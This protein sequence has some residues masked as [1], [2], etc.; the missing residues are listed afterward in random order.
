MKTYQKFILCFLFVLFAVSL[1]AQTP[2]GYYNNANDIQ[3]GAPLKTAFFHII[4]NPGVISYNGLWNAF[5]TTDKRPDGKVWDMYSDIPGGTPPYLYTFVTDQCGNYT[6]EGMCYNREHSMPKSWFNEAAPMNSDLFHIYPTDGYVNGRRGNLP[7]GEVGIYS[8]MSQNGSKIG[9]N[10]FDNYTATVFEPIDDYKG[11]FARSYFYMVTAFEDKVSNWNSAQL[12]NNTYPAFSAWSK[13]LL[14]KWHRMDPVSQKEIDRNNA[15]YIIQKNR[16]PYIDFPD[17]AEYVWGNK[18]N[19]VFHTSDNHNPENP[20]EA[21]Q[22]LVATDITTHSFVANWTAVSNATEYELEV[23]S[24]TEGSGT[25]VVLSENFDG[26]T[27]GQPNSSASSANI[28]ANI[29]DYTQ[30]PGWSGTYVFQA[31]GSAKFGSSSSLGTLVTPTIDLSAHNGSFNLYFEAM[32]WSGDSKILKIYLNDVLAHTVTDLN[33]DATYTFNDYTITVNGGTTSSVIRFEGGQASKGRFF[34][35][36]ISVEQGTPS[37]TTP[38]AGSPFTGIIETSQPVIQLNN[39]STYFYRV[40][41]KNASTSSIFSNEIAVELATT[42]IDSDHVS[43]KIYSAGD[44]LYVWLKNHVSE[45]IEIYSLLGNKLV[46]MKG[47]SG[48]NV[49]PLQSMKGNVVMVKIGGYMQKVWVR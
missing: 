39:T 40:R 19:E 25:N 33:N 30:T 5:K 27:Q 43:V 20:L 31:G 9:Q 46:E 14:M 8:W 4:K 6:G 42:H 44:N 34:L 24:K 3:G 28:A 10:T 29:N 37:V 45:K 16:N 35:E 22:A 47:Q 15:V 23:Y 1:S 17:L 36:N 49:I 32:A 11:D 38:I 2:G 21:P 13:E 7:F 26:F 41:A 48:M 18:M 12:G